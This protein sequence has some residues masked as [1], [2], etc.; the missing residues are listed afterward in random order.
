MTS[1]AQLLPSAE[2]ALEEGRQGS[3][4]VSVS[5]AHVSTRLLTKLGRFSWDDQRASVCR[6]SKVFINESRS[7]HASRD[8]HFQLTAQACVESL[9]LSLAGFSNSLLSYF[10]ATHSHSNL[11]ER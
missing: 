7:K 11:D 2:S 1:G 4:E 10:G 3:S 9:R 6:G 5:H 8:W